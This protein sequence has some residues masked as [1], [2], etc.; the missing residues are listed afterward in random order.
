MPRV[1]RSVVRSFKA[2]Y[3]KE[4][5]AFVKLGGHAVYWE[6]PERARL[7]VPAPARKDDWTDLGIWSIFDLGLDR[8]SIRKDGKFPGLATVRVPD[9]ALHIVRRRAER[10]SIHPEA[11]HT[12]KF[13][14][15]A[16]GACCR[17]NEVVL[18]DDDM[19]KFREA[20]R[21][22]LLKKPWSKRKDGKVI[23][24]LKENGRCHH[25]RRDN[26]CKIYD[27]RPSACS[28]FPVASECCIAAREY[29]LELFDGL[30]PEEWPWPE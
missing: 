22:D 15:L 7:V 2:K 17:K 29:E 13:D 9:D 5:A 18:D 28:V 11:T 14:C 10:D 30:A 23:L 27:I 4:A 25:L 19:A 16:C 6:S 3:A 20:N 26:K 21:A 8:W 12:S 24:T 1:V